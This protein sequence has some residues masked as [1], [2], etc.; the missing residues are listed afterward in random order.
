MFSLKKKVAFITGASA[1]IGLACAE[2]FAAAGAKLILTARRID[3][4]AQLSTELK[5]KYDT[6]SLCIK[7]DV[8]KQKEVN[9]AVDSLPGDWKNIDILVNNAGL[10]RGVETIAD[11]DL[12]NWDIM[13]DTNIKGLLNVSRKIIPIMKQRKAGHIINL[14]SIAGHQVY[15]GG[16]IYCAT[17]HAV[18]ALT[19]AMQIEL[20]DTP[21]RV[22]SVSPGMV[23]TEFSMIR[24]NGD[25]EK[26]KNVY[27]GLQPLTAE[28]IADA[29]VFCATR[30]PHVN[31]NDLIIMPVNQANVY[32]VHRES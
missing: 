14:G 26:A 28:D 24:F 5:E 8:R 1:G 30:P 11:G 21:I 13:I 32:A 29:V 19:Q 6:E 15:H 7:L 25:S 23:E 27:K 22:S 2:S 16:N 10:A 4:L 31:I 20:V 18:N 17:K 9:D 3:R 12:T